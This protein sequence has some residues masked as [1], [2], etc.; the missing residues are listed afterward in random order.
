MGW[1]RRGGEQAAKHA[2]HVS[3]R[4][5]RSMHQAHPIFRTPSNLDQKIWRYMD[6]TK[7]VSMLAKKALYF[8][9]VDQ[10]EDPFEASYPVSTIQ[11]EAEWMREVAKLPDM[12]PEDAQKILDMIP[13]LSQLRRGWRDSAAVNCWHANDHESAA[14]WKLYMSNAQ[15]IAVQS[16]F[17]RLCDS[18]AT[19]QH[20]V[21]VGLVE[22]IDYDR[23]AFSPGNSLQAFIHK[24][25]SFAHE[26]E[27]RAVVTHTRPVPDGSP[28]IPVE[29]QNVPVALE[30]LVERVCV[31]PGSATW[32]HEVVSE[33]IN[34]FGYAFP[35]DS[36][37][38]SKPALY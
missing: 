14:M 15:G 28:T 38:L 33:T 2:I 21:F 11:L 12:K 36:S 13:M 32:L 34:R 29:S 31:P 16:T 1:G 26:L 9:R 8:S 30:T 22:Y 20:P 4:Y 3:P 10:F 17:Q 35:V 19:F 23:Q 7:F 6:F 5:H 24:R 27:L 37:A 25:K 18:F